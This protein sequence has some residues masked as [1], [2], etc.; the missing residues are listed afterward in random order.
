MHVWLRGIKTLGIAKHQ[1]R[2]FILFFLC[3]YRSQI[4]VSN[5]VC[6]LDFHGFLQDSLRFIKIVPLE[7]N[8]PEVRQRL[9]LLR[10]KRE[11]GIEFPFR[12]PV[13]IELPVQVSDSEMNVRL[14]WCDFGGSLKFCEG[15]LSLVQAIKRFS[16]EHVCCG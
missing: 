10:I 15:V 5:A 3:E 14:L 7:L 8:V 16:H 1:K 2:I 6:A 13:L 11:L 12:V 9:R 4:K